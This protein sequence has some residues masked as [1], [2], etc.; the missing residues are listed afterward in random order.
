MTRQPVMVVTRLARRVYLPLSPS[1][2]WPAHFTLYIFIG[3]YY[4]SYE[5]FLKEIS[6]ISSLCPAST[7][8]L[9]PASP[10]TRSARRPYFP[11]VASCIG[12]THFINSK[13]NDNKLDTQG[14]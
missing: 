6:G 4:N 11:P 12:P 10:S 5:R 3:G 9:Q 2:L 8:S 7:S 13:Y 1:S 14:G